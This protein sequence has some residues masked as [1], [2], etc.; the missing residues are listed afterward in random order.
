[1]KRL[2][3]SLLVTVGLLSACGSNP[4]YDPTK[5]HHT[6][7][8]FTN[9]DY[10]DDKGFWA[11]MK[12]RWQRWFK[13]IPDAGDYDFELVKA[14]YTHLAHNP[15]IPSL[16]WIGHA[17]FLIQFADLNILT[18]PHFSDRASPLSWAGPKRVVPP[19]LTVAELPEIDA[20]IIS[21]DHY[22][23]LDVESVKQLARHNRERT[24]TFI[25]PL[26]LKAWF[27]N[28][29]LASVRIVELD[30]GQSH[31]V[32][33]V[34]FTA[35]PSQHW[36]KRSLFDAY[37]R[38]WASWVIEYDDNRIF[39]GGD[40]GYASHFKEIGKKYGDFELALLPIG[41][42]EPRWFMKPYHV[43]PEEA[44]KI[45]QDI[46]ARHSVAM[47]WGTFILT[48]EPLDEPP[49]KL[50]EALEKYQIPDKEFEVYQHG[51]SRH[52]GHLLA[53]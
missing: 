34:R 17:T 21:H 40:T 27:D 16:T 52:I 28:L 1:M 44:V 10:E 15:Q 29:E 26:G 3:T 43:N 37:E 24:L 42:Y 31:A 30:W 47:H 45:H 4:H 39:F 38:L 22:D 13:Q 2:R 20:V 53:D 6:E 14:N 12:W 9:I 48:D 11:F 5:P 51:E 32:G 46:N 7:S 50:A 49:V 23:S 35:E 8:G 25:V 36:S 18:D 19:A 33:D 41:A